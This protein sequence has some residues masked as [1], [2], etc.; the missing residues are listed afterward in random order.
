MVIG[1]FHPSLFL[2]GQ[3]FK[4]VQTKP[5]R[6]S[7]ISPFWLASLWLGSSYKWI[8]HGSRAPRCWTYYRS[9]RVI[10]SGPWFG[11]FFPL[12]W[13]VWCLSH[14]CLGPCPA[15][16]WRVHH[17]DWD[18]T[19]CCSTLP[20]Q[21]SVTSCLMSDHLPLQSA[22]LLLWSCCRFPEPHLDSFAFL[23][24]GG[25][26]WTEPLWKS[27]QCP[28]CPREG[29]PSQVLLSYRTGHEKWAVQGLTDCAHSLNKHLTSTFCVP[30]LSGLSEKRGAECDVNSDLLLTSSHTWTQA[31]W[32]EDGV[33][34]MLPV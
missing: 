16:F 9:L 31:V 10:P 19:L 18:L 6:L 29:C 28:P 32:W 17:R 4:L 30:A 33:S 3:I 11:S 12:L 22:N 8:L 14:F 2:P 1:T 26:L 23:P 27:S 34:E 15:E 25:S 20:L 7:K 21:T 13:W 24:L 5:E